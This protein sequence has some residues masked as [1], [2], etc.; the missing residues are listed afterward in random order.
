LHVGFCYPNINPMNEIEPMLAQWLEDSLR[1]KWV[2]GAVTTVDAGHTTGWRALPFTV[3]AQPVGGD[4]A[5]H[6]E[7]RT[8]TRIA[9]RHALLL[10]ARLKHRID[11]LSSKK[12]VS[13]W[14]HFSFT[15]MGSMDV[16]SLFHTPWVFDRR[17]GDPMGE[18]CR[19]LA[20]LAKNTNPKSFLMTIARRQELGLHLLRLIL[21]ESKLKANAIK[22]LDGA[23]RILP[24]VR[25]LEEHPDF[26]LALPALADLLHLSPS[27]FHHVFKEATGTAPMKF[28]QNMKLDQARQLLASTAST[29][30]E[31]AL[32]CG[33]D[34]TFH[35]SRLFKSRV[36]LSPLSFRKSLQHRR[37]F[38]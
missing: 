3:L 24:V 25:F 38:A 32:H 10:P 5:F 37:P 31:I 13:R 1:F 14:A 26:R 27:R 17:L 30:A 8:R 35:F 7:D 12:A 20:E 29:V 16:L 33:F 21:A 4:V 18:I 2:G 19:E 28:V 9:S 22:I 23:A 15:F 34:D 11:F 6:L 36:G